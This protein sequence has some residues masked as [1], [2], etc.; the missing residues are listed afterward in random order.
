MLKAMNG[1]L[2]PATFKYADNILYAYAKPSSIVATTVLA[3]VLTR[4]MPSLSMAL[5]IGLVLASIVLYDSK[6]KAKAQ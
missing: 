5:G 1:I 2:I 4:S 6:P 3:A